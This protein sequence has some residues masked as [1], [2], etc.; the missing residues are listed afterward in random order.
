MIGTSVSPNFSNCSCDSH[1]SNTSICPSTSKA[2]WNIR[3]GTLPKPAPASSSWRL[4]SSYVAAENPF[5]LKWN[6]SA[7][8]LLWSKDETRDSNTCRASTT[9]PTPLIHPPSFPTNPPR[10]FTRARVTCQLLL[11]LYEADQFR[12]G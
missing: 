6:A 12:D 3:P 8:G 5:G 10:R 9:R 2:Q 7:M 4:A 11:V 1:T